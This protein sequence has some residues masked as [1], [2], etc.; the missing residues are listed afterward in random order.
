M[1]VK[2]MKEY[3]EYIKNYLALSSDNYKVLKY[4]D[5]KCVICAN[6][7]NQILY[8]KFYNSTIYD[9]H[10]FAFLHKLLSDA[11]IAFPRS[12]RVAS[13]KK[14]YLFKEEAAQGDNLVFLASNK[15]FQMIA[16]SL[17]K[18]LGVLDLINIED[19][20]CYIPL[21]RN[22]NKPAS[23]IQAN[24]YAQFDFNLL[25]ESRIDF[26]YLEKARKVIKDALA[27]NEF[28]TL[29][30]NDINIWHLFFNESGFSGIIDFDMA[31]RGL[32]CSNLAQSVFS[33]INTRFESMIENV[34]KGYS[35]ANYI[36][37]SKSELIISY[38]YLYSLWKINNSLR[39]NDLD[40]F[41]FYYQKYKRFTL[42]YNNKSFPI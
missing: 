40:A 29:T 18:K 22:K 30:H 9:C 10:S 25:S 15:D 32:I 6:E 28:I 19:F 5:D 36:D 3:L 16:T 39:H 11:D 4:N 34:F 35:H 27:V 33:L 37:N 23:Q 8:Y 20:D 41:D 24:N 26:K 38:I 1:L 42:L 2:K 12:D 31:S 13:L 7:N 14:G 21:Y 17:G